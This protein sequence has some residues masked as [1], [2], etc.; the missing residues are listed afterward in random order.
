MSHYSVAVFTVDNGLSVG[1]LLSPYD[2]NISVE[3]HLYK[4]KKEIIDD[5]SGDAPLCCNK[6]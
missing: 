4:T 6:G 2:E 5:R 1:E 3:K